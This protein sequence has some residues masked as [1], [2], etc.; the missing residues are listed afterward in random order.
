MD[1]EK[2]SV[3]ST[4]GHQAVKHGSTSSCNCSGKLNLNLSS[5]SHKNLKAVEGAHIA[6][7]DEDTRPSSPSF[8]PKSKERGEPKTTASFLF[9]G[10]KSSNTLK[11]KQEPYPLRQDSSGAARIQAK[12]HCHNTS[13]QAPRLGLGLSTSMCAEGHPRTN[14]SALHDRRD[15][16]NSVVHCPVKKVEIWQGTKVEGDVEGREDIADDIEEDERNTGLAANLNKY[17]VSCGRAPSRLMRGKSSADASSEPRLASTIPRRDPRQDKTTR[18]EVALQQALATRAADRFEN[19]SA[20]WEDIM[21]ADPESNPL[22]RQVKAAYDEKLDELRAA[23]G[24]KD[25]RLAEYAAKCET[26]LQREEELRK[27]NAALSL[28]LKAKVLHIDSQREAIRRLREMLEG[29]TLGTQNPDEVP[30]ATFSIDYSHKPV[31]KGA[32]GHR[33]QLNASM[34]EGRSKPVIVPRLDLSRVYNKFEDAKI[35][36]VHCQPNDTLTSSLQEESQSVGDNGTC[37]P[38]ETSSVQEQ[39]SHSTT[40]GGDNPC[41]CQ[42]PVEEISKNQHRD[43]HVLRQNRRSVQATHLI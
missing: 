13:A 24:Q 11:P 9:S 19:I 1:K 38:S 43:L 6:K 26:A 42:H 31:E 33:R 16:S 29:R 3:G 22:L 18:L 36:V 20:V 28:E 4:I 14:C 5:S 37:G 41:P 8:G 30:R 21:A 27:Q 32:H 17:S 25:Q 34:V 12:H 40:P 7:P 15:G 2:R 10:T 23:A 39:S 35:V